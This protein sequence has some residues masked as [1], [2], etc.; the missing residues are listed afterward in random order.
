[1]TRAKNYG[2]PTEAAFPYKA[3][4]FGTSASFPTS[5]GICSASTVYKL[6]NDTTIST[7][8][9]ATA[10]QL[11]TLL[12]TAPLAVHID[13]DDG[14]MYYSSGV[15]TC[16]KTTILNTD[17]NHAVELIGYDSSGNY[18]IKNSWATTW[19]VNGY[20]TVAA[21][22]ACGIPN[23]VYQYV[24]AYVYNGTNNNTTNNTTNNS[25]NGSNTTNNTKKLFGS[26][27]TFAII[28]VLGLISLIFV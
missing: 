16:A 22:V 2:L 4:N 26:H 19:G 18:I 28:Y 12:T 23:L 9:M 1:M 13:A 7:Y 15:Y 21:G 8:S 25:T 11:K 14:F 6:P 5:S 17:L 20:G 3:S 10:T 24:S 27:M